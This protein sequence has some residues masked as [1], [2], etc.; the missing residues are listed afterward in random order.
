MNSTPSIKSARRI[1]RLFLSLATLPGLPIAAEPPSPRLSAPAI[2]W[3]LAADGSQVIEIAGI[4][5]SPRAGR[6]V[7][8]PSAARRTWNS[9][10]ADTILIRLDTGLYLISSNERPEHLPRQLIAIPAETDVTVA[11]DR[12]SAGFAICWVETCQARSTAGAIREQW[13][14]SPGSRPIAF[15]VDAG[16]VTATLESA[17]WRVGSQV[18]HLEAIPA[19]AAF[20]A[21][22]REL[23]LL[24]LAGHLA[25][26]DRQGRLTGEGNLIPNAAGLVG[27]LDGKAFFSANTE[28]AAAVLSLES[29]QTERLSIEDSVEGVWPAP[30][31]FAI[32][33]HE[34]AKRSIAIW[35]GQ[36]GVIGW[37][38]TAQGIEVRQ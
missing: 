27:S 34:S 17:V 11:W 3:V 12:A 18:I 21:G 9:P 33:L 5:E 25:G 22:T 26:Q 8:L 1:A 6:S 30:G 29:A 13:E 7:A 20:R 2:G 16:L 10:D 24:D 28:G 36:T 38:P 31:L 37:M 32:R 14:V 4:A 19:A 15:S 35:N 23:W